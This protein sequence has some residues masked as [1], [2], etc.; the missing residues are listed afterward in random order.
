MKVFSDLAGNTFVDSIISKVE[1][2]KTSICNIEPLSGNDS[3]VL[4]LTDTSVEISKSLINTKLNNIS[5]PYEDSGDSLIFSNKDLIQL[6]YSVG[7]SVCFGVLNGGAATSYY[8]EGKNSSFDSQL[9]EKTASLFKKQAEQFRDLPKALVPAALNPDGSPGASFLQ[10]KL[11]SLIQFM[12]EVMQITGRQSRVPFIQMTSE[13]TDDILNGYCNDLKSSISFEELLKSRNLKKF[14]FLSFQQT[15]VPA[16]IKRGS[17][18]FPFLDGEGNSVML[19]GGHGQ[20]Y[21]AIKEYLNHLVLNNIKY[22]SIGNIDNIGYSLNPLLIGLAEVAGVDSIFEFA[23]RT[24]LDVKGGILGHCKG[25]LCCGEIGSSVSLEDIC[26]FEADHSSV[27]FNCATGLF[28]V[29]FLLKYIDQIV[30]K[31]PLRISK[32]QKDFGEYYAVEQ[33]MWDIIGILDTPV[34]AGVDK[35]QRFLPSK[36]FLENLITTGIPAE[37]SEI[38]ENANWS[39]LKLMKQLNR[40][41]SKI[42]SK[43]SLLEELLEN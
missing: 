19:P 30:E 33:N 6:G 31:L 26:A 39:N 21:V 14:D 9:F 10:I 36:F 42:I 8:D 34:I 43:L 38:V 28:N 13:L 40:S 27:L 11:A 3:S 12:D 22:L 4:N 15:L 41:Y 18:Y 29:K 23:Y 32:Q 35:E 1:K 7:D 20:F 2:N 17:R 24:E 5:L 37:A 16:L 25:H